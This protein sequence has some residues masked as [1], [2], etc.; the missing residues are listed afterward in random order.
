[1]NRSPKPVADLPLELQTMRMIQFHQKITT[2]RHERSE[3]R[4][5]LAIAMGGSPDR[6]RSRQ[7]E[8]HPSC[9]LLYLLMD[10]SLYDILMEACMCYIFNGTATCISSYPTE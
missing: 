8:S 1:M 4:R 5:E 3:D 2:T 6:P 9:L 7:G 10:E